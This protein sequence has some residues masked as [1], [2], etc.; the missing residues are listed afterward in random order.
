MPSDVPSHDRVEPVGLGLGASM[1]PTGA[2]SDQ[3]YP[4]LAWIPVID[5]DGLV[6]DAFFSDQSIPAPLGRRV[7]ARQFLDSTFSKKF[8]SHLLC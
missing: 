2:S 8:H 1:S 5:G 7:F 4:K 3:F 6:S